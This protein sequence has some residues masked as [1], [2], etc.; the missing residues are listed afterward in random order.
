M[1][2]KLSEKIGINR[3]TLLTYLHFLEECG[4]IYGL[5]QNV[6]GISLLQKPEKIYLNNPNLAF[7][8]GS[9]VDVGNVR[10]TFFLNQLSAEHQLSLPKN[11]DFLID[12]SWVVEVG[13]KNKKSNPNCDIYAI[14]TIEY[15]HDKRIPLWLFGFLY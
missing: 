10:E 1:G 15:G 2:S 9:N 4:L 14:D 13:G 7:A 12:K 3:T 6:E 11:S 8:L 5:H